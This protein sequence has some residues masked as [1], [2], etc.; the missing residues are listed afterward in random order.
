M[1]QEETEKL[2]A[3]LK[4]WADT[5]YGRRAE[6]ARM[7]GVHRRQ[8]TNWISG[9]KAPTLEQDC[10]CKLSLRNSLPGGHCASFGRLS[11][12]IQKSLKLPGLQSFVLG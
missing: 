8:I 4:A 9:R 7:L 5:E 1:S 2:M 11:T 10:D 6:I 12:E 3:E